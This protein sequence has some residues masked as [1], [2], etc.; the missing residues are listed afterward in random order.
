MDKKM[1]CTLAYV[2]FLLYLCSA[3]Y[4]KTK[5]NNRYG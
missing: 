3:F 2:I 1:A 5:I 4:V